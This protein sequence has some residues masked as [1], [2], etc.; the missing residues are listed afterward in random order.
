MNKFQLFLSFLCICLLGGCSEEDEAGGIRLTDGTTSNQTIFADE[1]APDGGIHFTTDG[2][3]TAEVT[4]ASTKADG[5]DANWVSLDKYSGNAAGDYTITVFTRKNYTGKDRKAYIKITCGST[6]TIT[7]EQKGTTESGDIPVSFDQT[8]DGKAPYVKLEAQELPLP[9]FVH[10]HFA[11]NFKTN[12]IEPPLLIMELPGVEEQEEDIAVV[13]DIMLSGSDDDSRLLLT[14]FPN[15]QDKERVVTLRFLTHDEEQLAAVVLRQERGAVCRLLDKQMEVGGLVFRFQANPQVSSVLYGLSDKQ[16]QSDKLI[17]E[18]LSDRTKSKELSLAEGA[19]EFTLNFDGLLPATTYYL[20]LL[21]FH[22]SGDGKADYVR[23]EATTSMLD[24]KHDLVL[25]VSA[26]AVNDFTV[27]LPFSDHNLKGTID[28]GDGTVNKVEGFN[29][30][31][32]SHKYTVQSSTTYEVHFSGVLTSLELVPYIREAKENTL[33]AVKQWGYTGLT[34]IDLGG[35]SSLKSIAADTEGA[36]R[37]VEHFGV[38]PYGGSFTDTGI[39]SI[40]DG[41]FKYAVNATSF[42]YTFGSC[43]NLKSIPAGLFKNCVKATS[44]QRTFI[45][46][47]LLKEIPEDIF[48]GCKAATTFSTTFAMCTSLENIPANLF[49]NNTEVTSF[50][51]TFSHCT[52]LK[53]IPATLFANCGKVLYLGMSKLRDDSYRGGLGVFQECESLQAIPEA[54]FAGCPLAQDFSYAFAG[55]KL[56]T[57]LPGNL[58]KQNTKLQQVEGT[59]MNCKALTSIPTGLFDNNRKLMNVGWTFSQSPNIEGES[60]YTLIE[61]KKVH[62]YERGNYPAEFIAL[63]EYQRCFNQCTKLTDYAAIPESW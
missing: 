26:N 31:G 3:W 52:S 12:L 14:V 36:F 50:E 44:F 13:E 41:F 40:P 42:D 32:I 58:F 20:Y 17:E 2:A 7:I 38:E 15:T 54:L 63:Q 43:K 46:C 45:E 53:S 35:F 34:R 29:P 4:M 39:E 25:E 24:S 48:S 27:R 23:E 51:G 21:P 37:N 22:K 62:L 57:S 18:F 33:L 6:L 5:D 16:L 8:F 60:P 28:W 9:A 30:E 59:F 1:T 55:C 19:E 61:G 11:V 56:L 10:G 47:G 49:A